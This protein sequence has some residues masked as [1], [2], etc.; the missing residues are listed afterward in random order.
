MGLASRPNLIIFCV[1]LLQWTW[2]FTAKKLGNL[3]HEKIWEFTA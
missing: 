3:L 1:S 2:G